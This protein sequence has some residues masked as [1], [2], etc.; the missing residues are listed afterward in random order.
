MT[1][2]RVKVM[3]LGARDG[4]G[5]QDGGFDSLVLVGFQRRVRGEAARGITRLDAA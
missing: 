2:R 1:P 3:K 4:I 5:Q